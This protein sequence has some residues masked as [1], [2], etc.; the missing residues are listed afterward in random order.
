MFRA[1]QRSIALRVCSVYRT[2]SGDAAALLA[3]V[4]PFELVAAERRQ[5][6]TRVRE[7]MEAGRIPNTER[8]TEEEKAATRSQWRVYLERENAPGRITREAIV[9]HLDAWLDRGWG[10]LEFTLTQMLTRH[11][12]FGQYLWQMQKRASSECLDCGEGYSDVPGHTLFECAA[13]QMQRITFR[14]NF[15]TERTL[16]DIIGAITAGKEKWQEF[17][18]YVGEIIRLKIWAERARERQ[19]DIQ[20]SPD[21]IE[22]V[23]EDGA[24]LDLI[25]RRR[26]EVRRPPDEEG[27]EWEMDASE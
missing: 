11:G 25:W 9:P 27:I 8:I 4:A 12:C 3:R 19:E 21:S 24:Q 1:V 15:G 14:E 20:D 23:E 13:W 6:Y 2:V 16:R 22:R 5:I 18:R 7:A 17:A 10:T 26:H